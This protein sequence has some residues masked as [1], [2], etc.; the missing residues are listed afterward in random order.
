MIS[1]ILAIITALCVLGIDQYTKIFMLDFLSGKANMTTEFIPGFMDFSL[2][3]NGGG[4]WGMLE[5]NT[6]LLLSITIV[7]MLV[8]ITLLFKMGPENKLMFWSICLILGGGIGNMID[9]IFRHGEVIDFLQLT[10]IDFPIFNIADIAIVIGA[11]LLMLYFV[12]STVEDN[13]LKRLGKIKKSA[14]EN[15]TEA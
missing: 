9:R 14:A 2:T 1:Y 3:L 7:V 5:G 11:G 10:F 12:I 4:A 13:K 6:W 15:D 8:C